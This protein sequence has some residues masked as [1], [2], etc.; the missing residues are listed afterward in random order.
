[1]GHH[2]M[3]LDIG[4]DSFLIDCGILMPGPWDPGVD[5]IT[6]SF[7]PAVERWQSGRLR[8]LLLTHGHIDH[9]GAV[10][11]LLARLPDLPV[12]GTPW[13]LALVRRRLAKDELA[14]GRASELRR[15]APGE[16]VQIG[17]SS[18]EWLRV[19]HS[20]PEASSL[21]VWSDA[22]CVVH[23][24]D[25]RIQDS[26]LLGPPSDEAGLRRLGD[27]G[28]DLALVDSTSSAGHGS[29]TAEAVVA[30]RITRAI[31]GTPGYVVVTMFSSHV[32]RL[33]GIVLAARASGRRVCLLG[34]SLVETAALAVERG[35]LPLEAGELLPTDQLGSVPRSGV[36]LV[37]TGTQ[38]EFR[39]P[40]ARM[41]R[42]ED[43][44][45]RLGPGDRVLW[46][47]RV[48]PGQER[49]VGLVVNRLVE[50]GVDVLPPWGQ[51]EA[52]HTSG[53]GRRD[54][55][56]RW[57]GWVRP[58]HV[59]PIHGEPWHLEA[60]RRALEGVVAPARILTLRSGQQLHR[61]APEQSWTLKTLPPSGPTHHAVGSVTFAASDPSLSARRR[62]GRAGAMVV[63]VR[64]EARHPP[65]LVEV[66]TTGVVPE[67]TRER[68]DAGL[69]AGLRTELEERKAAPEL[70][71]RR[72][73]VRLLARAAVRR[74]TD[75]KP[76]CVVRLLS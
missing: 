7:E 46:S 52:L 67:A 53:H 47:A 29:T 41:S 58:R 25:F 72:E 31:D 18:A 56:A 10:P 22:G 66:V 48:I 64:W 74:A 59:V 5:R 49:A 28:V 15:V 14:V 12:Y 2:H 45:V 65:D 63:L 13:T 24:G 33:W 21:A 70:D 36:V 20:I 42:G 75:S 69:S 71:D 30:D 61:E 6:P 73:Q 1:M 55:V 9:I 16:A 4:P 57:L 27:R 37:V 51:S 23:S 50:L 54:E 68:F 35:M 39:A 11:D 40:L 62:A 8:G 26:P 32:E 38:G 76:V 3:V 43:R 34:R 44:L 19:T 60:H 17:A